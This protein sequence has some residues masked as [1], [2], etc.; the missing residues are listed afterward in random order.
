MRL[1]GATN[2]TIRAPFVLES[3]VAGMAGGLF[4]AAALIASKIY[5][6]DHRFARQT[7]FPLFGW[8]AVWAA[9]VGVLLIGT[10]ASAAMAFVA[11][12]RHLHV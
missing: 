6:V 5:L 4:A 10:G 7:A 8:E 2:G 1:V 3:A 9:A 11:L 12:R